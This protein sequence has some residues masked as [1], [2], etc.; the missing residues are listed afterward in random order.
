MVD[1]ILFQSYVNDVFP[2]VYVSYDVQYLSMVMVQ[3]K[4]EKKEKKN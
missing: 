2:I 4:L 3:L 1:Q